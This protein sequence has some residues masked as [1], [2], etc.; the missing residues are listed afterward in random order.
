[1]GKAFQMQIISLY[2]KLV[3]SP[4]LRIRI[5]SIIGESVLVRMQERKSL[6]TSLY[7]CP[8]ALC[9]KRRG[10]NLVPLAV[11]NKY[12]KNRYEGS[13]GKLQIHPYHPVQK[14]KTIK[15]RAMNIIVDKN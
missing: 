10:G 7:G 8:L 6:G 13:V 2:C 5:Q 11:S 4:I 1:M 12:K 9:I 14:R 15:K 3:P